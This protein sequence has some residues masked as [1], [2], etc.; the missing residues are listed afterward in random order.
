[1]NVQELDAPTSATSDDR[2]EAPDTSAALSK[3]GSKLWVPV[4]IAALLT[5][6]VVAGL[7]VLRTDTGDE[8]SPSALEEALVLQGQGDLDGAA[9]LFAEVVDD[10]G[11]NLYALYNLGLIAQTRGHAEDAI[12]MY[13]RALQEDRTYGPALFNSALAH[14]EN[15]DSATAANRLATLLEVDPNNAQAMFQLGLILVAD[16]DLEQ[17][18]ELLNLAVSLDPSLRP[19]E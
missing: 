8:P 12:V 4:S 13:E 15:G 6:A 9:N 17:G 19:A 16:G 1:M 5:I 14:L 10:E 3:P 2:V 11:D 18:T 7:V